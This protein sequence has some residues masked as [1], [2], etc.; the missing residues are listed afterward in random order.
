MQCEPQ[1]EINYSLNKTA[2]IRIR[3]SCGARD[4]RH[5]ARLN[6]YTPLC[7]SVTALT[8]V[9]CGTATFCLRTDQCCSLTAVASSLRIV[10]TYGTNST[11]LLTAYS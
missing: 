4:E 2:S 1:Q 3:L 8:P 7:C 6:A 10:F 11:A 9:Y 5:P